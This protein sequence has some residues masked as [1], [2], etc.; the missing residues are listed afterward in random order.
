MDKPK[1]LIVGTVA[2]KGGIQTHLRTL[3]KALSE[4]EIEHLVVCLG[5]PGNQ[6]DASNYQHPFISLSALAASKSREETSRFLHSLRKLTV[7]RDIVDNF[8]PNL[9]LTVGQGWN[10]IAPIF[11][12]RSKPK[13]IFYEVMAIGPIGWRDSRWIIRWLFDAVMAQ[14][15]IVAQNYADKF[16]WRKPI[17]VLPAFSEALE[18]EGSLPIAQPKVVPFGEAKAAF[19]G[20]LAPHKQA[21]WLV[22]QWPLLKNCLAEL[23]IYGGGPEE[24]AIQTYIASAGIGDRVKC[25]GRYPEGQAYINL[26]SRY[27][28][29]LL[30]TLGPEG[31]PLALLESMACGVPFVTYGVGGIPDLEPGNP[32]ILIVQPGSDLFIPGVEQMASKLSNGQINPARLQQFYLNH[33]SYEVLKQIWL[34]YLVASCN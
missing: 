18:V 32:D 26:L 2:G 31:I 14:S 4:Q 34:S 16:G 19:F 24:E 22:Q 28:L 21:F 17:Q 6:S 20:R 30:P 8:Y 33:H 25:L 1:V 23:H 29:T 12:C 3:S 11:M 7:L 5:E 27:D 15:A 10:A 13:R 9:Y